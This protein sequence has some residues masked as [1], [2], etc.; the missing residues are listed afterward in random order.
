[1]GARLRCGVAA[2]LVGAAGAAAKDPLSAGFKPVV[3]GNFMRSECAR[4]LPPP[5][6]CARSRLKPR[7]PPVPPAP[8]KPLVCAAE[9]ARQLTPRELPRVPPA[10]VQAEIHEHLA[11]VSTGPDENMMRMLFEAE[12]DPALVFLKAVRPSPLPRTG[13]RAVLASS[14]PAER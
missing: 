12:P 13:P 10:V 5:P 11:D 7:P 1:M 9:P 14:C 2:A 8:P 3:E 4:P 6:P